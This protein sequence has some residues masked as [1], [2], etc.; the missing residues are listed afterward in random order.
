[1]VRCYHWNLRAQKLWIDTKNS[2]KKFGGVQE[3]QKKMMFIYQSSNHIIQLGRASSLAWFTGL[4]QRWLKR[5]GKTK[6]AL[7]I[8]NW[9]NRN[10]SYH[11]SW[12]VPSP[13]TAITAS[14]PSRIAYK[15]LSQQ[16]DR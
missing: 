14:A 9:T 5:K 8:E 2:F 7:S 15:S 16:K 13:P 12:K 6:S 10:E 1:M 11:T 3:K 4:N